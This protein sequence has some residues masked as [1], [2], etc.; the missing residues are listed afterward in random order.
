MSLASIPILS[1]LYSKDEFGVWA[2]F[3]AL[4]MIGK[5]IACGGFHVSLMLPKEEKK[6]VD[7]LALSYAFNWL[8][9]GISL[10]VIL[11]IL[12]FAPTVIA[13]SQV[14]LF[15]IAIPLSVFIEGKAQAIHNW[16]NRD[17]KYKEMSYSTVAQ[18]ATTVVLSILFGFL[19]LRL[20]GL[21]LGTLI[22]Q[23]AMLLALLYLSKL[24]F[25]LKASF[26]RMKVAYKEYKSFL[27]LGVTGNLI[28][29][30][31]SQLPFVFFGGTFGETMNGQFSMVQQKILAAPINLVSAAVSPVFFKE[32]NKAHLAQDGSL[33]KLVSQVNLVMWSLIIIPVIVV[34][35]WGPDVFSFVLGE[36]W[37]TSGEYAQ[38]LAPLMGVRFVTHPLSYLI[39]VKQR[40][41][42]QLIFNSLLLI[43]TIVIFFQPILELTSFDTI[44]TYGVFVFILQ[45]IFLMYLYR[46][47]I[48]E[49]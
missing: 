9:I 47:R 7:L 5:T 29:N 39:D 13:P 8:T 28:N 1:R 3:M 42:A 6:A 43:A 19:D 20:N 31:A 41:R 14:T 15:I 17:M 37:R 46:L 34:M 32:A 12:F 45:V 11:L 2:I 35:L 44:R 23:V 25:F 33:K 38:W 24:P 49:H 48:D 27:T 10:A 22:G 16:L 40:L 18:T 30:S 21:I 4:M 26:E 36:E